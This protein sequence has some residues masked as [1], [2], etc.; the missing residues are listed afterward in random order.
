[1]ASQGLDTDKIRRQLLEESSDVTALQLA[2][3]DQLAFRVD[4]PWI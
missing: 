2:R 4:E 3:D 1:L